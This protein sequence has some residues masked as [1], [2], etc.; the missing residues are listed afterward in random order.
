MKT[1]TFNE[2]LKK[3]FDPPILKTMYK[4]NMKG[5]KRE[6]SHRELLN[7]YKRAYKNQ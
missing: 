6:W 3:Y 2:W 5:D 4:S 7:R 1:P